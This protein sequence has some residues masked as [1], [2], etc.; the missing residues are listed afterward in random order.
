LSVVADADT[1]FLDTETTGLGADAEVVDIAL[2]GV[3][4]GVLFE[5]LIRPSHPIPPGASRVHRIRDADVAAA[6]TWAEVQPYLADLLDE[7]RVVVYNAAFDHRIVSQCCRQHGLLAPSSGW[8]CAMHAYAAFAALP[9]AGRGGFRW[10][11]L[12]A[13]TAACG[14]AT[15]G[16]RAASDAI[17]CRGVVLA[18]AAVG[19]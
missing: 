15:G 12:E 1:V 16:H 19:W 9:S 3:D 8:D 18:M 5:S 11:K 7:R 13:A 10:H 2:I 17:A 14:V 6:P 4:G